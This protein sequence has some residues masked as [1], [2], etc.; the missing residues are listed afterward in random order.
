MAGVWIDH[1]A[2]WL[3]NSDLK[4]RLYKDVKEAGFTIRKEDWD[5]DMVRDLATGREA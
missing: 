1:G 2:H 4:H 3:H 5:R